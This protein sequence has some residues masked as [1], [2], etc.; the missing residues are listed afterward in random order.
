[1]ARLAKKYEITYYVKGKKKRVV[2]KSA[3]ERDAIISSMKRGGFREN[4]EKIT[5]KVVKKQNL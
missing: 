1:M 2:S 5:Y 3:K 4:Y